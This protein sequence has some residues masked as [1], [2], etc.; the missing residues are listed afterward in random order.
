MHPDGSMDAVRWT[1][2]EF[3]RMGD[4][5][6]PPDHFEFNFRTGESCDKEKAL[7]IY[8]CDAFYYNYPR[9]LKEDRET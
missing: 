7:Y 9:L 1:D 3:F 8:M 5:G 2:F 6:I 4:D